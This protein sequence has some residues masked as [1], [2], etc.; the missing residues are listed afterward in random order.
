MTRKKPKPGHRQSPVKFNKE[1]EQY[2]LINYE[3]T[4]DPIK[5]LNLPKPVEDRL[6]DLLD[7]VKNNT[8]QAIKELLVL[9]ENY[10]DVPVLYNYL[11]S[12][13][14]S[15]GNHT[16]SREIALENYQ[17]HPDYLFAKINYAQICLLEGEPDKIPEIFDG[18]LDLSL[19]YPNRR[20]YH[21]S[22]FAG[23]TGVMCAYFAATGKL[24]PARLSYKCLLELAPDEGITGFAKAF[25]YPSLLGRL[26][27]WLRR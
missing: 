23:F 24:E 18:N 2:R 26:A 11:S 16:A 6:P 21:V 17:K 4:Y 7:M 20:R 22:E 15:I 19:L 27:R 13:Y 8:K 14:A 1:G 25:L 3:I 5:R 9:K 12:A 10:P